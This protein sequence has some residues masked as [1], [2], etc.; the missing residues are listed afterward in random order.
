MNMGAS[1]FSCRL[2]SVEMFI[3]DR[4]SFQVVFHLKV[5]L[6]IR[7]THFCLF[8]SRWCSQKACESRRSRS[9]PGP[10]CGQRCAERVVGGGRLSP[11]R[12]G[13]YPIELRWGGQTELCSADQ[14][15]NGGGA[16]LGEPC[17]LG[18]ICGERPQVRRSRRAA[19]GSCPG[20][21]ELG[22]WAAGLTSSF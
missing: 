16:V 3:V 19:R 10:A 21:A 22:R 4:H 6:L 15:G 7:C 2:C 5:V 13:R 18:G 17:P 14:Q 9:P 8:F 12:A 11:W 20:L 1:L